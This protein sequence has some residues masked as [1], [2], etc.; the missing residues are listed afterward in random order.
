VRC[1]SR[2]RL[3]E[4]AEDYPWVGPA[5]EPLRGQLPL[6]RDRLDDIWSQSGAVERAA[7]AAGGSSSAFLSGESPHDALLRALSAIGVMEVRSNGKVNVPD[8]FRVE[9]GIK[10][11]GGVKPP[12][13]GA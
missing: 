8:I 6:A 5:L 11:R 13:G 7:G 12:R 2:D 9:A 1:A 4:L 10:R 3:N